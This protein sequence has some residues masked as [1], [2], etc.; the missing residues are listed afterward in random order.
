[1][2]S[3][4]AAPLSAPRR[5]ATYSRMTVSGSTSGRPS[6]PLIIAWWLTPMPSRK[7]PAD[8]SLSVSAAWAMAAGWRG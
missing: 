7:R 3:K 4:A 2:P 8:S 1:L 6:M 5:T